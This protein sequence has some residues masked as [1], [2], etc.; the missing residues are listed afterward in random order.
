MNNCIG[1]EVLFAKFMNSINENDK[2]FAEKIGVSGNISVS[3]DL[4]EE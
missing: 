4:I 2:I 1:A 3:G